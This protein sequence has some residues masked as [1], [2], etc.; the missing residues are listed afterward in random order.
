LQSLDVKITSSLEEKERSGILTFTVPHREKL[1]EIYQ[2]NHVRISV[3]DGI[4]VSPH[5]YNTREDIDRLVDIL[6]EFI[7]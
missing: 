7:S 2:K 1:A 6:K 4:R 5:I 3:R